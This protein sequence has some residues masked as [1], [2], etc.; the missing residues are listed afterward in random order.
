MSILSASKI[1][2]GDEARDKG[3]SKAPWVGR[4]KARE[5]QLSTRK[6]LG[7]GLGFGFGFEFGFGLD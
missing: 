7:L 2:E 1:E 4:D 3:L 5:T 6:G